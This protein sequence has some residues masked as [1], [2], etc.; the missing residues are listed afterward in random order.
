MQKKIQRYGW[1]VSLPDHRNLKYKID[2]PIPLPQAVDLRP[3]CPPV[4]DQ[5][6]LGSC[7]AN[8]IAA[9]IEF[10]L[11]KQGKTVFTPSRLFIYYN[12]RDIENT[13]SSDSGAEISD[14]IKSVNQIGVCDELLWPYDITQFAIK[15]PQTAYDA[16][17][18]D[19]ITLYQT[20]DNN[21]LYMLK[22][23]LAKGFP[24]VF[25]FTVYEGFEYD[26]VAVDGIVNMPDQFEQ[27]LGGHAVMAV[28]YD[29]TQQRAII[30]NS[31]GSD[32][33]LNG[34]FTLPYQY[35]QTLASD[36]KVIN[37]A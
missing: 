15:P 19:L 13:V 32:W 20:L 11:M 35:L 25:G 29:D 7:T 37:A 14:G 16:A 18:T 10:D 21:S 1:R 23:C 2:A 26:H 24:F 34:Y 4:Y 8:A 5:G 28:G 31:W 12:E 36:F 6:E 17:K 3:N 33:A 9:A 22:Q 27:I 30:R